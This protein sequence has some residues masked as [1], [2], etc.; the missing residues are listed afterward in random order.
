MVVS[1][2]RELGARYDARG[3]AA[4]LAAPTSPMP[5]FPLDQSARMDLAAH[6]LDRYE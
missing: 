3:L 2:L 5:L 4:F 6:L 1:P